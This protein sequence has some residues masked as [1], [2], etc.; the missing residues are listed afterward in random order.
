MKNGLS[1]PFTTA[2]TRMLFSFLVAAVLVVV[3]AM[4]MQLQLVPL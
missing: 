4:M 3:P 2:A 1:N